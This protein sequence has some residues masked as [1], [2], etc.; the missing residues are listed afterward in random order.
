M[1]KIS[2]IALLSI[3]YPGFVMGYSYTNE[4]HGYSVEQISQSAYN[5][6][7][8]QNSSAP[9]FKTENTYYKWIAPDLTQY[10]TAAETDVFVSTTQGEEPFD[11]LVLDSLGNVSIQH[12]YPVNFSS[13][14]S[15]TNNRRQI[16]YDA[17]LNSL[18]EDF[19]SNNLSP[20]LGS[21][22]YG[23]AIKNR[24]TIDSV[25]SNFI[26]NRVVYVYSD[27]SGGVY[28]GAISN[29]G[30]ISSISGDFIR[31]YTEATYGISYGG[32]IYNTGTLTLVNS[33]FVGNSTN[34]KKSFGGALFNAGNIG[35]INGNFIN[36]IANG[37]SDSNKYG[38]AIYNYETINSVNGDFISNSAKVGGAIYNNYGIINSINGDFIGNSADNAAAIYNGHNT[39]AEHVTHSGIT[40]RVIYTINGNFINNSATNN[41]GAIYNDSNSIIESLSGIFSRN[42]AQTGGAIYNLGSIGMH[43]T[44]RFE[45]SS[46]TIYNAGTISTDGTIDNKANVYLQSVSGNGNLNLNGYTN[47]YLTNGQTISQNNLNISENSTLYTATNG[48]SVNHIVNDGLISLTNGTLEQNISYYAHGGNV[49][50]SGSVSGSANKINIDT[51]NKG[52]LTL[53][54]GTLSKV[55]SGSGSTVIDG[56]VVSSV[57]MAQNTTINSD[58]TLEVSANNIHSD[59]LTNNGL[60]KLSGGTLSENISLYGNTEITGSVTANAD[61]L[62]VATTNKG[63]LTLNGGTISN[64]ITGTGGSIVIDG[65]VIANEV[66]SQNTTINQNKSLTVSANNIDS[67]SFTNNGTLNLDGGSLSRNI[68]GNGEIVIL[69]DTTSNVALNQNTTINTGKS[70]TISASNISANKLTNNGSLLFNGGILS[71]NISEYGDVQNIGNLSANANYLNTDFTNNNTLTLTGGSL[72]HDI[73]G[74]GNII[75]GGNVVSGVNMAQQ[76]TINNSGSLTVSV[77]HIKDTNLTNNGTLWFSEGILDKAMSNYGNAGVSGA[78]TANANYLNQNI[79]NTG[80]LTLT[81]GVLSK[82]ISGNGNTII[83]GNVTASANNLKQATRVNSGNL[84]LT[85]G[86]LST[87]LTGGTAINTGVLNSV[88]SNIQNSQFINNGTLNLNGGSLS[89]NISGSGNT[90]LA[91]VDFGSNHIQIQ[92]GSTVIDGVLQLNIEHLSED[93]SVYTGGHLDVIGN[94]NINPNSELRLVIAPSLLANNQSTGAL[95]LISVSGSRSGDFD[96]VTNNNMYSISKSGN[97]YIIYQGSSIADVIQSVNNNPNLVNAG[98]AWNNGVFANNTVK[99]EVQYALNYLMQYDA[100][101][102]VEGLDNLVPTEANVASISFRNIN[103]GIIKQFSER[104][105]G[106]KAEGRSGGDIADAKMNIWAQALFNKSEQTGQTKFEADASGVTFGAESIFDDKFMLGIGYTY[107]KTTTKSGA[108]TLDGNN[109]IF[110]IYAE[111]DMEDLYLNGGISYGIASYEQST[112]Y[113]N[114]AKFNANTYSLNAAVGYN[115]GKY[116]PEIRAIYIN[117]SVDKYKDDAGQEIQYDAN[118]VLSLVPSVKYKDSFTTKSAKVTPE[119]GLGIIYDIISSDSV[120]KVDLGSAQYSVY[121]EKINPFGVNFN[122]GT[123]VYVGD[124]NFAIGYDLEWRNNFISHTGR[125]KAKY[126]F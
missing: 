59:S 89:R 56:N 95:D 92:N 118:S 121:G 68:S 63:V 35:V 126:A 109:S 108:K 42:T 96:Y 120:A 113:Q 93:S 66:L 48:L 114:T 58:R 25:D 52:A 74:S 123:G 10:K 87:N 32:A 50:I 107:G 71:E 75:I 54:G 105:N 4:N 79:T 3:I 38:G 12:Y 125:I 112:K 117:T 101:G 106:L 13:S 80:T 73:S 37:K 81:E 17:H 70:L 5:T 36:N 29:G 19:I 94:L 90:T 104:F 7:L 115:M 62:N 8:S 119:I 116:T 14:A 47:A 33:D 15:S 40:D 99:H 83:N 1:K 18:T 44:V 103:T 28:G 51:T 72:Q 23:A 111:Y 39:S 67:N 53:T 24:G 49:E 31:N 26:F 69:E 60:L 22:E 6:A 2:F 85:G 57:N 86:T 11:F 27:N 64:S 122:I 97:K 20:S 46:D 77:N 30:V 16:A 9:V 124:W 84:T 76:T 41:G 55:V 102:Y 88:A 82:N 78:L 43:N 110:S 91:N 98:K 21:T 45:T 65:A 61:K 34:G 100:E